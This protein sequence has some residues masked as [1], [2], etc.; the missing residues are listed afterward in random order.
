MNEESAGESL[1][2]LQDQ[3]RSVIQHINTKGIQSE[4]FSKDKEDQTV[5][6]LQMDFAM[7]YS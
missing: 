6:M 3:L 4:D 7:N 1:S 2:K 5:R